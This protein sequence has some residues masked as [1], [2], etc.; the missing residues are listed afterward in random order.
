MKKFLGFIICL[1]FGLIFSNFVYANEN[2]DIQK[3]VNYQKYINDIGINI[4]NSNMINKRIVFSYNKGDY[5]KTINDP[6]IS[7]RQI[8]FYEE[9]FKYVENDDELAAF[10]AEQIS[11]AVKSYSGEWGGLVASAQ[12]KAAP[13]KYEIF[14]EKRAV[15]YLVKAGYNPLGLITFINKSAPQGMFDKLLFHNSPSKRMAVVYEYIYYNYPYFLQNNTYITNKNYQ[16]F[17]LNS[18]SN[19]KLLEEK[20]KTKSTKELKYE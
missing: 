15:D 10:L 14:A 17:L 3:E 2:L 4:L 16:N 8:I 13:K 19:R 1:A 6:A 7:K 9:Y 12:I 11:R 5:K 18:T 20:I